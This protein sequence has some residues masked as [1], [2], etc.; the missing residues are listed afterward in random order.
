MTSRYEMD[1]IDKNDKK[2]MDVNKQLVLTFKKDILK[3][4]LKRNITMTVK[5]FMLLLKCSSFEYTWNFL[6]YIYI[7]FVGMQNNPKLFIWLCNQFKY[8]NYYKTYHKIDNTSNEHLRMHMIKCITIVTA[9]DKHMKVFAKMGTKHKRPMV[10]QLVIHRVEKILDDLQIDKHKN[11]SF[12]QMEMRDI[13]IIL[14]HLNLQD[15]DSLFKHIDLVINRN[16]KLTIHILLNYFEMYMNKY[17]HMS[18][19]IDV[20]RQLYDTLVTTNI[21]EYDTNYKYVLKYIVYE[22]CSIVKL[23]DIGMLKLNDE[24]FDKGLEKLLKNPYCII[25]NLMSTY[26]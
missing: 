17:N 15:P 26:F 25:N 19:V 22:L 6:W 12:G 8:F 10:S 18:V 3:S 21:T 13:V 23:V 9:S 1:K 4:L 14:N 24:K 16:D 2:T 7:K 5:T 11:D 20:T